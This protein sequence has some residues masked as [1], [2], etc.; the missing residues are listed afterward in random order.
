M[1]E[2]LNVNFLGIGMISPFILA[3]APPARNR[4]MIGRD[5]HFNN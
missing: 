1:K 5:V 3:S 4:E 2:Q